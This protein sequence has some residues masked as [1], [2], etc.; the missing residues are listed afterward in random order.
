MDLSVVI[1]NY[2]VRFFL[3]QCLKSVFKS[4]AGL[5]MEV[6][7]VDNNSVDG[8]VDMVREKFPAVRLIANRENAGF[9]RANNQA[10]RESSG[11]HV[12]LLNPDTV[13]QDDTLPGVVAFMEAHPDAGGLGVKMLDGQGRFLPESKRGLPTPGVA[14]CKVF[15]LSALFPRSRTFGRYHLG[16]LDPD[17]THRVDVLS[18]AFMLLRREAL[19]KAG[20][21]DEDFFMYGEDIDLS[22]R[23]TQAGYRNYYYPGT[24]II[25]YKGESTKKSSIN[26]VLVFYRAM[27]I[28][29]RKHFSRKN[30]RLFS[31]LIHLAVWFRAGIAIAGRFARKVF[32]PVLDAALVYGGMV[33]IK[34]SW[35][36]QVLMAGDT[37]YPPLF[38]LAVVPAYILFWLAG[39]YLSG[40]YDKPVRSFRIVRG[41]GWGTLGILVVYALLPEALRFSRALI[42]LGSLWALVSM[43]L[44]RL[45]I[46]LLRQGTWPSGEADKKRVLVAGDG[47]EAERIVRLLR[48]SGATSFIGQA[49]QKEQK[50][51]GADFLG[52][53]HQLREIVQIYAIDEVIF[54]AGALPSSAIIDHMAGLS[55]EGVAFKIAPPES[56]FLIGS[57]SIDTFSELYAIRLNAIDR[58][59]NRRNKRLFD[60]AGAFFL[61]AGLPLHLLLVHRPAGLLRNLLWVL[62]G[63]KSWIGY[64][65]GNASHPL[66]RLKPG[67]LYPGD[68]LRVR[69][70]HEDTL[71]KLNGLYAKDY[72]IENDVNIFFRA[73]RK[74]GRC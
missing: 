33:F 65:P 3:E 54:C 20:T 57:N 29:A 41:I 28:F 49:S 7:V 58:P 39:V 34:N 4:G 66:P 44:S 30:A 1:V 16:Y 48:E 74:L 2:N 67:V 52:T 21:L 73:Y 45:L 42:L 18:G 10:I 70:L 31:L 15:G 8:S 43:L 72:K 32:W 19:E 50:P 61:L 56:L 64:H 68:G 51:A 24:R 62:L 40:G 36:H 53:V 37:Y 63:K 17:Q 55:P 25:H 26:Y 14:F 59:G 69:Q 71:H 46:S 11:R 38:M 22:Y 27:V 13:L 35:E 12:L 47:P 60:L 6:F 9:S 23:I 5:E